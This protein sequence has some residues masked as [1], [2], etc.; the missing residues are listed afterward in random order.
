M[1][2]ETGI[3]VF[4][5]TH[6]VDEA[7]LLSDRILLMSPGPNARISE[8]ITIDIPRPRTRETVIDHPSYYDLRNRI[9]RF[10]NQEI[11]N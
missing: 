1:W 10:L 8:E 9:I 7:I 3:T 11:A 5:V 2:Q 4:M 6:D